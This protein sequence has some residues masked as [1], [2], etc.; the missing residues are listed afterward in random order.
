VKHLLGSSGWDNKANALARFQALYVA[1]WIYYPVEKGTYMIDVTDPKDVAKGWATLPDRWSSHLSGKGRTAG[2]GFKFL[3][4][5]SELLVQIEGNWLFLKAEGHGAKDLKHLASYFTKLKTGAGNTQS[6]ALKRLAKEQ[7]KLGITPRAAENYGKAYEKLLQKKFSLKGKQVDIRTAVKA[8]ID[9]CKKDDLSE[10]DKLLKD[11]QLP[12][13][14]LSKMTN[15][16][17]G[18]LIV[19][20]IIPFA[21]G[22][23]K[24]KFGAMVQDAQDDL[25]GIADK[26]CEDENIGLT[27]TPRF[28]QELRLTAAELDTGLGAFIDVLNGAEPQDS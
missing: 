27:M 19:N 28:F 21:K 15:R 6:E 9:K 12:T 10:Y 4:G 20:V 25:K 17:I 3:Q 1:C 14:D 5:Y 7:K 2:E 22:L 16:A 24:S 13:D 26:L 18:S 23:S 11:A 8:M